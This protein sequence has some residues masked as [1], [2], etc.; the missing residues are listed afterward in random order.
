MFWS[1]SQKGSGVDIVVY[2]ALLYALCDNRQVEKAVE[3]LSKIL[4]K[5]LKAPKQCLHHLYLSQCSTGEDI[6]GIKRLINEALIRGGI[7]SLVGYS[8]MAIDL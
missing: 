8:A 2:R 5:G 6:E 4:R 3:I 1:I 7:R